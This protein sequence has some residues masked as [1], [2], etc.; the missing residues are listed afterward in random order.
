MAAKKINW[1]VSRADADRIAAI[2]KRAHAEEDRLGHERTPG[3]DMDI[4]AC[5]ANGCPLDL[6]G[7]LAADAFNFV[8]DVYGI[9][10]HICR[11]TG[12]VRNFVPRFAMQS[13]GG[14]A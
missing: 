7:L 9:H 5:H 2:V 12:R 8:H 1:K 6:S 13:A 4:T 11:K 3:L 10:A 14:G